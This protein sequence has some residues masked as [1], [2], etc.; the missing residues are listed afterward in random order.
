MDV[1]WPF[2]GLQSYSGLKLIKIFSIRGGCNFVGNFLSLRARSLDV[3]IAMQF[4]ATR[5][6]GVC[7]IISSD[8]S[9]YRAFIKTAGKI[10]QSNGLDDF[11]QRVNEKK[12]E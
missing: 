7:W 10:N 9:G 4:S 6:R 3:K 5:W 1:G 11:P 12:L 2:V 8:L